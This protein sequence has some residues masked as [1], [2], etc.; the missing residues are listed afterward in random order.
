MVFFLKQ[1]RIKLTA[2]QVETAPFPAVPRRGRTVGIV[3]LLTLV[4]AF[5]G[6]LREAT[7]A[8]R[9]GLSATMDAYFAAVFVPTLVYMVLIAGTLSPVFIPIL[10][11]DEAAE[12]RIKLSETFSVVTNFVVL[13][14]VLTIIACLLTVHWWLPLF[15]S[16]FNVATVAI[17][18]RL[19]YI[20]FPAILF[21]AVAGILTAVLNGFHKFALAA[22]APAL[23]SIAVIGAALLVQG[24]KAIYVV[25]VATALGFLLQ[26]LLLMPATAGLGLRYRL[27]LNL[28]HPA[29]RK[30]LHLGTPLL[31]YLAVA[32]ASS[33]L[34]RNLA[35]QISAGAVS[36]ISYATR[37]FSI[38]ANFFAAPLAIVAYPLF[39][40]EAV[41]HN[42]GDLRDQ[43]YRMVRLVWVVFL[44]LTVWVV[45]NS[46]PLT[47]VFYEHGQF[48]S[49][50]SLITARVLMLY[51]I[52]VLP[53][54][55]TVILLRCFYAIQDTV[56]PLWAELIDLTFYVV[57]ALFLTKHF[58]L[59]GLAVTRGM[60]FFLVAII[61]VLVLWRKK[62]LLVLDL[63]LIS[64]C[65]RSG[66]AAIAMAMVSWISLHLLQT[67][68]DSGKTLLRFGIVGLILV[69]SGG[70][71][72]GFARMLKLD[73][74]NHILNMVLELVSGILSLGSKSLPKNL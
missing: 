50:D 57:A 17:A 10:I 13:V 60:T 54:A 30:L 52:G 26:F 24:D 20:I 5:L 42:Y 45:M 22:F 9:F 23:S 27:I 29:L 70:T 28:P 8:A 4:V 44:P 40:R 32:N 39:A 66:L 3:S 47:R 51:G 41:R 73:E 61:L 35:S 15:F 59:A 71:F 49:G 67:S 63:N 55:V 25:G 16:G 38:P 7:L 33:F 62:K 36:T 11:Q 48:R 31:L 2:R 43:L 34:E 53:N 21:V 56:T 69:V 68:F 12:D 37:L 6:Y 74:A 65:G 1:V 58:G 64:F 19:V 14:L 72:L 18:V 46:L